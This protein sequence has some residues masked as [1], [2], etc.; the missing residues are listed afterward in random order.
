ME[1]DQQPPPP[2][3]AS[4]P[5]DRQHQL[6]SL[7]ASVVTLTLLPFVEPSE[8]LSFRVVC[9]TAYAFV[10]GHRLAIDD[11]DDDDDDDDANKQDE[12]TA[13]TEEE[14]NILWRK[15][16]YLDFGFLS[17]E[18]ERRLEQYCAEDEF[19]QSSAEFR[20]LV[21]AKR[22]YRRMFLQTFRYR[23]SRTSDNDVS[24]ARSFLETG[25]VF[26]APTPFA[27]WKHWTKLRNQFQSCAVHADATT[28][29]SSGLYGPYYLRSAALWRKIEN[30]CDRQGSFGLRIKEGLLP[31]RAVDVSSLIDDEDDD[32]D[33]MDFIY[34]A[35]Q[36]IWCFY[37]G[38]KRP[39]ASIDSFTGLLGGY[40][41]YD[42]F[43]CTRLINI[44]EIMARRR[45]M[46]HSYGNLLP[47][48]SSSIARS[49]KMILI[50]REV[51]RAYV[52]VVSDS[53]RRMP[54]DV[55]EWLD[56]YA[57]RLEQGV[58]ECG[59]LIPSQQAEF[60]DTRSI[61][62]YPSIADS[63]GRTSRAVTRGV[64]V[65]A[66]GVDAAERQGMFI[67]S[68]R[69]RLVKQGE[70]GYMT[71]S[72]RGFITCQLRSRHWIISQ[73]RDDEP[74][75]VRGDGVVG[76]YPLLKE[77]G[78]HLY[79]GRTAVTAQEVETDCEGI[80]S[81]QSATEASEHG[82]LEG[83]LQFVPGSLASPTGKDF[84]VRVAPFPLGG[85]SI[86]F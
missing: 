79:E 41:A 42:L 67:Y 62:L 9:H 57:S 55:V 29:S 23:P 76:M 20:E 72:E 40:S 35:V 51:G 46:G 44:E 65:V 70:D 71:P 45:G 78:Y 69:I 10:H 49:Q 39:A 4:P 17:E 74:E 68:I 27:S 48:A 54:C 85:E 53:I 18:E 30:W 50:I 56:T 81:Y 73:G 22:R 11:D 25:E 19:A 21:E 83:S 43:S 24:T 66:S 28:G 77:G 37:G 58:Y 13:A 84:D 75:H 5:G 33:P 61:L 38:Q 15:A 86:V 82:A 3:P 63:T 31:G 12:A 34:S 60:S 8:L 16:L 1:I 47:F 14:A 59:E 26:A 7:P 64:E 52:G 2:L 80:F 36:A 32:P 6:D